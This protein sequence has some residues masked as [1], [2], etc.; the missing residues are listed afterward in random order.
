[1]ND[2]SC[3]FISASRKHVK[4]C[5]V[6]KMCL[7]VYWRNGAEVCEIVGCRGRAGVP[8]GGGANGKLGGPAVCYLEQGHAATD[9]SNTS[10]KQHP[11]RLVYPLRGRGTPV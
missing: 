2:T 9:H 3:P 4:L 10:A 8:A 6:P 7:H 11:N 1:M 5:S